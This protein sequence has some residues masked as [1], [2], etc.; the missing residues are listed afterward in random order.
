MCVRPKEIS[1]PTC[2]EVLSIEQRAKIAMICDAASKGTK[3]MDQLTDEIFNEGIIINAAQ[4]NYMQDVGVLSELVVHLLTMLNENPFFFRDNAN[5]LDEAALVA[6][7][8]HDSRYQPKEGV[9]TKASECLLQKLK[10]PATESVS[11]SIS[12]APAAPVHSALDF[13][14]LANKEA[15]TPKLMRQAATWVLHSQAFT[16]RQQEAYDRSHQ[17]KVQTTLAPASMTTAPASRLKTSR[18][19]RSAYPS[20]ELP[21]HWDADRVIAYAKTLAPNEGYAGRFDL[22]APMVEDTRPHK[23]PLPELNEWL[24]AEE[25]AEQAASQDAEPARQWSRED[26]ERSAELTRLMKEYHDE[27]DAAAE[28]SGGRAPP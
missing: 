1:M 13:N 3:G 27:I 18:N 2:E 28:A 6:L 11:E 4:R 25:A 8:V 17:S 7:K 26:E 22:E 20:I 12:Q 14:P 16:K 19:K 10:A 15:K 5:A 23:M 9:A 24:D 21:Y